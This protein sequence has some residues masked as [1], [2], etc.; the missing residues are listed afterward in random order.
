MSTEVNSFLDRIANKI[1]VKRE[2][3]SENKTPD[4]YSDICIIPFFGDMQSEFLLSTI[5]LPD[6]LANKYI[7]LLSWPEH[8]GIYNGIHEYWSIDDNEILRDLNRGVSQFSNSIGDNYEKLLLKYFDNVFLAKDLIKDQYDCGFKGEKDIY[9]SLPTLPS[10]NLAWKEDTLGKN[11]FISPSRYI[12]TLSKGGT[13]SST[14]NETFWTTLI[15]GLLKMKYTP[16]VYQDYRTYDM[17]KFGSSCKY[18]ARNNLLAVLSVMRSCECVLDIFDG[19]SRYALMA[20][21]PY[22]IC[23]ERQKYFEMGDYEI[24]DLCG[25]KICKKIIY[26]FSPLANT[27]SVT[28][29]SNIVLNGLD[30][31]LSKKSKE[32]L[33]STSESK[34]LLPIS[35]IRKGKN[36][37]MSARYIK[38]SPSI[39]D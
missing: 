24:D 2:M 36:R 13:A 9:Y 16:I 25:S 19:L 14:I 23:T 26:S 27:E 17:S 1:H 39:E 15:E 12:Y 28:H 18:L 10:V 29:L 21:C 6:V 8:Y 7:I 30:E 32:I 31:F 11:I 22:I 38:V 3:F 34:T 20:R 37:G 5:F 35:L 33:P 4:R